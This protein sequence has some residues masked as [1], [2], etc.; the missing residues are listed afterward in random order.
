M[1]KNMI[2]N[3]FMYINMNCFSI[4]LRLIN[5]VNQLYFKKK[6]TAE[7]ANGPEEQEAERCPQP[8][9]ALIPSPKASAA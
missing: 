4:H 3:T 2:R 8:V 1:E 5:I 6:K 7:G 9:P